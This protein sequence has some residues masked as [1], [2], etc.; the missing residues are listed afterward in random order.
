M[1]LYRVKIHLQRPGHGAD[2][3][4]DGLK[5]VNVAQSVLIEIKYCD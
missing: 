5:T 4:I 2:T 3:M 1:R